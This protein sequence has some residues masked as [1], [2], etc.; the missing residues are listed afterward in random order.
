LILLVCLS[1][2]ADDVPSAQFDVERFEIL[3]ENPLTAGN[4]ELALA[5]FLG[6][7]QG[8]DRL[9]EA[10]NALESALADAGF[11][12]HRVTVPPQ[13]VSAGT[14]ELKIVSFIVGEIL[15]E[16]NEHFSDENIRRSVPQLASGMTPSASQFAQATELANRH[17]SKKLAINLRPGQAADT[18]DAVVKVRDR[19]PWQVFSTINNIG[20]ET[21]GRSRLAIGGQAN[22]LF[23][24]DH[25]LTTSYTTSP[26][27]AD[28][29][30]QYGVHYAAPIYKYSATLSAFYTHSDVDSGTVGNF[31]DVSGSGDFFGFNFSQ[32]LRNRGRYSH[33][34]FAGIQDRSFENNISFRGVPLAGRGAGYPGSPPF[35]THRAQFGQ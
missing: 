1:A 14:I 7:L 11:S 28:D 26:E 27:N 9:L 15:V 31:F 18:V 29:V 20:S 13:T 6:R 30:K 34:W 12:F 23:G 33:E 3:G 4:T 5:P 21:S 10:A 19:R 24:L 32:S 2:S 17:P 22:N 8:V 16:N 35:R 25:A